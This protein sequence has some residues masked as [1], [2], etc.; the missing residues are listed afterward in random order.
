MEEKNDFWQD[1]D[2]LIKSV[3]K[4]KVIV[5]GGD[6]NGHGGEGNIGDEIIIGRYDAGTRNKEESMVVDFA[7]RIDLAFVKT[8]FKKMNTGR[9]IKVAEKISK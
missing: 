4:Q 7:K 2:G 5:L 1:L 3:S 8:Y 9:R 6:L